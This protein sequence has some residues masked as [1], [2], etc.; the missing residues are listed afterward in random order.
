MSAEI[1]RRAADVME[2]YGFVHAAI[3]E[4]LRKEAARIESGEQAEALPTSLDLAR[5]YL[6][7]AES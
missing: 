1:L 5:T 4:G 2:G 6:E 7:G 3:A